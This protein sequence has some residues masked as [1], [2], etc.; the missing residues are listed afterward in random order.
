MESTYKVKNFISPN[1]LLRD[2]HL[3]VVL[4]TTH[5]LPLTIHDVLPTIFALDMTVILAKAGSCQTAH[6]GK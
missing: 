4:A 5:E 2:Q 6:S 3:Y 1:F